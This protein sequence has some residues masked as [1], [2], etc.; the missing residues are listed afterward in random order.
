VRRLKSVALWTGVAAVVAAVVVTVVMH[1]RPVAN[2]P[3]ASDASHEERVENAQIEVL[4]DPEAAAARIAA[5]LR[6]LHIE[7]RLG[8]DHGNPT[9]GANIPPEK[10][11][12]VN[13]VIHPY[14]VPSNNSLAFEF[15]KSASGE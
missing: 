15:R 9:L 2:A 11:K 5:E 3:V 10:N 12:A 8:H 7:V 6:R 13:A 4:A 1:N 14:S